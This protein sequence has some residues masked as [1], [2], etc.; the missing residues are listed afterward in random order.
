[1]SPV[2]ERSMDDV[3]GA[4]HQDAVAGVGARRAGVVEGLDVPDVDRVG[5]PLP[6]DLHAAV[7]VV[8]GGH[9]R[10][11]DVGKV[12]RPVGPEE[13]DARPPEPAD[14]HV[15]D[16]DPGLRHARQVAGEADAVAHVRREPRPDQIEVGD[17]ELPRVGH[18][19]ARLLAGIDGR[20]PV[21]VRADGDGADVLAVERQVAVERGPAL[22]QDLVPRPEADLV[23]VVDGLPGLRGRGA[24][25]AIAPRRTDVVGRVRLGDS[26]WPGAAAHGQTGEVVGLDAGLV[27]PGE[28]LQGDVV[29]AVGTAVAAG[30]E[31]PA[32]DR[33]CEL[34]GGGVD[35]E[36]DR[37]E[38]V[39]RP[40]GA[41]RA[42]TQQPA[43]VPQLVLAAGPHQH[44][45]AG[46]D[47]E[48][49]RGG[50]EDN[51]GPV[52]GGRASARTERVDRDAEVL[53]AQAVRPE[54]APQRHEREG[55]P[56]RR[57]VRQAKR[58]GQG[59][60]V[61]LGQAVQRPA[62]SRR[63]ALQVRHRREQST[64]PA[65]QGVVHIAPPASARVRFGLERILQQRHRG[66]AAVLEDL[67]AW[68]EPAFCGW[69]HGWLLF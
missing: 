5:L 16:R 60:V 20:L 46:T 67:E 2:T 15:A 29:A 48:R 66:H 62:R 34:A 1:L 8:V 58:L 39:G 53:Q 21:A 12:A 24:R 6:L 55:L 38:L 11:R 65:R 41:G 42:A 19:D 54:I 36:V 44:A 18:E 3:G 30:E 26:L 40:L 27:A 14:R 45:R 4:E 35:R 25:V 10:H 28:V 22:E 59:R 31:R 51:R 49:A 63:D 50:A 56:G 64:L 9:E 17:R 61:H 52:V 57:L 23:H 69:R 33:Q 32:V 47:H 7:A 68:T 13:F 37:V 43:V